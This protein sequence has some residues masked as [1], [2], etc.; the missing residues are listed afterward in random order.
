MKRVMRRLLGPGL[1]T[2][3]MMLVLVGLGSWQVQRL[4]WKQALLAEID[5][6]EVA[7]PVP[8]PDN[9]SP[10]AKVSVTGTFLPGASALYGA[11]V[12]RMPSGVEM[13]ARLIEPMRQTNGD[14][15][16]IDRGWVP[17]ARA[18][19]IEQPKGTVTVEGYVRYGDPPH[20]F[21]AQ[22]DAVGRRFY[23]LDPAKIGA[24]VGQRNV[25][26]FV[27]VNFVAS[28]A[29]D[30]VVERLPDP[31]KHLPRPPNNHL[32][33]AITWYGLA[34]AL[35]AIFVIWSHRA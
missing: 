13:G 19:P 32:A 9:P 29:P 22:D 12:R 18:R 34:V 28:A 7:Q 23:T 16:L 14:I 24:A 4:F 3:A 33:Y 1:M 5:R 10:F 27:L 20:W 17:L 25:R 35:L 21:S 15:I 30:S 2:V 11:D 8:L 31:A 26:P 6:A